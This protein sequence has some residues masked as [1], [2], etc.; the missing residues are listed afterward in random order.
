MKVKS[1]LFSIFFIG[2]SLL[3]NAQANSEDVLMTIAGKNV[4]VSEFMA[5]YQKNNPKGTTIDKKSLDEYLNLYVNFKLKVKQAE[6]LGYDTVAAF[7]TELK[8]YRDQLAKPYLIDEDQIDLLVQEA[9]ERKHWD[10]RASHI[11]V[12]LPKDATPADTLEAFK[13]ISKIND[14][15]K[16]GEDFG[17]LAAELSED[18]SARDREANQQHP[19]I[20]GNNGDLGYFT[21]FDFIYAFEC[22]A[23]TTEVGKI[24][25]ITRTEYG[26]HVIKVTDKR[27]AMGTVTV[28]HIFRPVVKDA[29]HADS[30]NV[31]LVMDTVY[32][33]LQMGAKWDS[34]VHQYSEDKGSAMKGGVLPKFGVNKL[35][36]EFISVVYNL[37]KKGD[38]SKPFTTSYGWHIVKLVDRQTPG[39]FEEEKAELKKKI[40]SDSRYDFAKNAMYNKIKKENGFVEYPETKDAMYQVVTDSIFN[41]KWDVTLAKDLNKPMMKVGETNFT[42]Q[43]FAKYLARTQKKREKIGIPIYVNMQYNAFVPDNLLKYQDAHLE[44]KYPEF[45]NLMTEYRDGILLFNLTDEKVWTKAVKDTV[46]LKEFYER[47]KVNYMW[48]QRVDATIYTLKNPKQAQKV[49]NFLKSGL[50]DQDLLKEINSDTSKT[51]S[52]ETGKF[53]RKDNKYIDATPWVVGMSADL[54]ADSTSNAIVIETLK[55]F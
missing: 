30:A 8:G 26:Y 13:K 20:K 16:N 35:V 36:P 10:V 1:T 51:L 22:A 14:R 52:F 9:F 19:F 50:S 43:D 49:R 41:G 4:T 55:V 3:L 40:I 11:F 18:P 54:K 33:K 31:A 42:Q 21:V 48:G 12:K 29:T 24:S 15:V 46:G 5:I 39:T 34:L 17:K 27:K 45:R 44:Q 7:K 47:N 6:D 38:Y 53:S 28:A 32:N 2:I 25:A 37:E 23:Y